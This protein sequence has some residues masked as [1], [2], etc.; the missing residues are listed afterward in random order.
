[1]PVDFHQVLTKIIVRSI[2][3]PLFFYIG[4]VSK[5]VVK[6]LFPGLHSSNLTHDFIIGL[7]TRWCAVSLDWIKISR[8]MRPVSWIFYFYFYFSVISSF[9]TSTSLQKILIAI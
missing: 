2:G 4:V 1:M 9:Y 5:N 6:F 7:Y 3:L 8:S